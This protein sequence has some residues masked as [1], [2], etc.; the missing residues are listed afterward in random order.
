MAIGYEH[1]RLK[2]LYCSKICK[3]VMKHGMPLVFTHV[4][5]CCTGLSNCFAMYSPL[6][7][8]AANANSACNDS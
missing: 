3:A 1:K 8:K 7:Y 2:K 4:M 6:G 5:S